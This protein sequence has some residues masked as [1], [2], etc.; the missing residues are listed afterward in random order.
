MR[1]SNGL[2]IR[3]A[4][5][6]LVPA[7]LCMVGLYLV[8]SSDYKEAFGSA[9]VRLEAQT[10]YSLA[11]LSADPSASAP[12]FAVSRIPVEDTL[13]PGETLGDVFLGLGLSRGEAATAVNAL[14]KHLDVRRLQ[15]GSS[16][17]A[18]YDGDLDLVAWQIALD[19]RGKVVVE[20]RGA[21]WAASVQPF[22]D[23]TETR[24]VRGR[25][26]G[27][28]SES[29]D[30]AG[31]PASLAY[32]MADVLQWDLDFSRDLRK[33]DRFQVLFE[34]VWRDREYH[35]VG[36]ILALSYDNAGR[37]VEAFRFGDEGGYYDGDGRP[38]KKMFLRSPMRFTR[39]TSKFTH[40]R[41]HPVL[42]RYRPHYGV[43]YGAPTGTPV[44]VTASGVVT[45]A[46]RNGGAGNMVKVRHP[47]GYLSAY[48]HLSGFAKDVRPGKRLGQGDLVGY[49]GATGLATGPHLDYRVQKNGQWID[50]QTLKSVPAQPV[51]AE[52]RPRFE[53][54]RDAA[55][56]AMTLDTP[57]VAPGPVAR[58]E[59]GVAIAETERETEIGADGQTFYPVSAGR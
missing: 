51:S 15:A 16:Y 30:R 6:L 14:S 35:G 5:R 7:T 55:R 25:L 11:K 59:T 21:A 19:D 3:R 46:G 44:R 48:L 9:P 13:H 31:G 4:V 57:F 40:R 50:P 20:R 34:E 52:Q 22:V 53:A 43:D 45:F 26:D 27:S 37:R 17:L 10:P 2:F 32:R 29:I 36:A 38:L 8:G 54:Y 12:T 49:V 42:K 18:T 47:N 33:G 58:P 41:F 24:M 1:E 39:V 23:R 56:T 28:L